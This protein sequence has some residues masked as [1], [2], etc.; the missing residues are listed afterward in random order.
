[1]NAILS[2]VAQHILTLGRELRCAPFPPVK[3]TFH[4]TG[5]GLSRFAQE[6][7]I[8]RCIARRHVNYMFNTPLHRTPGLGA[9]FKDR[10]IKTAHRW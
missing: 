6:N 9:I 2:I 1:M 8:A 7:V 4:M 3:A 5:R 10:D